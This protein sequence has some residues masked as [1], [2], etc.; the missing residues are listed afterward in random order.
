M[1]VL[2]FFLLSAGAAASLDGA[3]VETE[4]GTLG[5]APFR[6][7]VPKPWNGDL[8]MYCHGYSPAP[9][10]YRRGEPSA[11]VRPFLARGFAVA[12]S[13]FSKGG[14]AIEEGIRDTEA[15][16]A[17]FTRS[18]GAPGRVYVAGQSMG[19]FL[20]LVLLEK[21]P[22]VY[23]GGLAMCGP[24]G[25]ASRFMARR[26][27]DLRVVFDHYFPGALP[28]PDRVPRDFRSDR[29]RQEVQQLLTRSPE[30]A[31]LVRRFAGITN[32]Q[33]LA[34]AL[35]LFTEILGDLWRRS[36]GAPVGNINVVYAL[37][38]GNLLDINGAVSR[39]QG[40]PGAAAYLT[41]YYRPEGILAAP[42]ISLQTLYDPLIPTTVVNEYATTALQKGRERLFVQRV[43]PRSGHCAFDQKDVEDA[44]AELVRLA[45]ARPNG[46][47]VVRR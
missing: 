12:Q 4:I 2:L 24:L 40:D 15:L 3:A 1:N 20:T 26:A 44:F 41:R 9:I 29:A 33:E 14:W 8:L 6:V 39:Y 19:G 27:L 42:L 18:H 28:A 37:E 7:D 30:K 45:V 13:G 35:A 32:D 11:A 46:S 38:P 22:R 34:T 36:G 5:V 10:Q 43:V 21:F 16:R 47:N 31:T 25:D 17:H 23:A